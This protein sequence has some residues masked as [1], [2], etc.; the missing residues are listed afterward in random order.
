MPVLWEQVLNND[1]TYIDVFVKIYDITAYE[2]YSE[3][4][5]VEGHTGYQRVFLVSQVNLP[6]FPN[7]GKPVLHPDA[8][9]AVFPLHMVFLSDMRKIKI[10]D[11]ILLIET[12]KEFA[13]SDRYITRHICIPL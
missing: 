7:P 3:V 10:T 13:V 1:L 8:E 6:V 9:A 4:F 2:E 12:D 11:V 5:M